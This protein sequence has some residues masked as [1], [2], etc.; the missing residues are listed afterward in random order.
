MEFAIVD[1]ETT[2]GAPSGGGIT[3]IAVLIHDGDEIVRE[4]QTLINPGH[5]I[6][7]YITGLT[8]ID[9]SM[10]WDAP[11]FSE[12]A[13]ELW[14]L[15]E[16][17]VFVAHSVN[18]D[19]GFVREAFSKIGKE[20]NSPKLC[21]VRLARK[22]Y[23]GLSSY[24][25]GR[26][27]ENQKIPI[28]ARHRAMGDAKATA[29]LFDRMI[30]VNQEAVYSSL[31]KNSGEAFLPPNFPV[32]RFR[33]IPE[34]CGV[35]YMLNGK[36][37]IIYVGKALNIRDRF[38]GHFSG[39]VLPHLKQQLK[40]EV[41]DL[42]WQLT[43]SEVMAL[44]VETLEIKRLWPAFNSALKL[45]K[46]LWGLFHYH[47]GAGFYRFQVAKVTK[48]LRPLETFFSSEEAVQ[49]LKSGIE[50][51][52]LCQKLCG[53]R[54]AHCEVLQD[55]SCLGACKSV[56]NPTAYNA[57]VEGFL[58]LIYESKKD[59]PAATGSGSAS[60]WSPPAPT[61]RVPG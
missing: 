23:P 57:R 19:F 59:T 42:Q 37:K 6:P 52:Q 55:E 43:G 1:I 31:K 32:S 13:A 36:G 14:D 28:L 39:Q 7:G 24:S 48:N 26:I 33:Q 25:L 21:T 49:F 4:F 9:D 58:K 53:L 29:L 35:Y 46:T 44:L 15:L 30:K 50:T 20:L 22:V 17:R 8:G 18:F 45:P 27:C 34:S 47:D 12:I 54:K 2:G 10:V 56:E 60:P 61:M 3:E 16:G 11:A 5:R 38:K 40:G 51:Y 41:T